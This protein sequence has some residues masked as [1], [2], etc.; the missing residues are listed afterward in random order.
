MLVH[1]DDRGGRFLVLLEKKRVVALFFL[2]LNGFAGHLQKLHL[3][4]GVPL[5]GV[6]GLLEQRGLTLGTRGGFGGS[7]ALRRAQELSLCI[8]LLPKAP[9]QGPHP[10]RRVWFH[11]STTTDQPP[12]FARYIVRVCN[13]IYGSKSS[14]NCIS[15]R[16]EE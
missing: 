15:F 13:N 11:L 14:S 9:R 12:D 2:H 10:H 3:H 7:L 5:L 1:R 4:L 16:L 8:D 6:D